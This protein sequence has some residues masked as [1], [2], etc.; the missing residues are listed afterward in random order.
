MHRTQQLTFEKF[1]MRQSSA[2]NNCDP[3]VF[4][5]TW[6]ESIK[7]AL[8]WFGIDRLT[9]FPN[10]MVM[11]NDGRTASVAK[12]NIPKLEKKDFLGIDPTQYMKLL[13]TKKQFL[14]M[15]TKELKKTNNPV[16]QVIYNE[17]GRWHSIIPLPLFGQ[18]WGAITFTIFSEDFDGFEDKQMQRLKLLCEIWLSYWQHFVLS[19]SLRQNTLSLKGDNDKLLRLSSK[20]MAVLTLLSQGSSAKKC[21]EQLHLSPRTIESHKYRMLDILELDSHNDLLQFALRNGLGIIEE[22]A[23]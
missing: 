18:Q 13:K 21:G 2:L 4:F 5:E 3:L 8:D 23:D 1:L 12:P 7:E 20:Q 14:S 17:G 10:S 11:L 9:L 6:T 19:R 15:N 22:H 16:L